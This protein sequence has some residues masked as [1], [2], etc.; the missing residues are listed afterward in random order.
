MIKNAITIS[1]LA[2]IAGGVL[3][4]QGPGFGRGFAG[5]QGA[6]Q[7]TTDFRLERWSQLLSLD[8]GQ[9]QQAKTII[10]N[11]SAAE[12]AVQPE[13]IQAR[14]NLQAAVK[15]GGDIDNLAASLGTLLGKMHAIQANA[16]AQFYRILTPSQR[17]QWDKYQAAGLCVGLGPCGGGTGRGMGRG[18]GMM[19]VGPGRRQ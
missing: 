9:Q 6:A 19:G 11:A 4:A 1:V 7:T 17:E 3:L 10:E 2:T 13:L 15:T 12:Q 5:G 8:A 16:M 14:A 18:M